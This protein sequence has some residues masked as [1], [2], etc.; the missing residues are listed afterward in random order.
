MNDLKE[1]VVNNQG[2]D[3]IALVE[4]PQPLMDNPALW[5]KNGDSPAEMILA[6]AVLVGALTRL[7]QVVGPWFK[8]QDG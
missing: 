8:K 5:L 6:I 2:V 4:Q 1:Q 3:T 7:I